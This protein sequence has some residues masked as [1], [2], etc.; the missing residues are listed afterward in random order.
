MTFWEKT[1]FNNTVSV[2]FTAIIIAVAVMLV[3]WI[4]KRFVM[5]RLFR[6]VSKTDTLVDDLCAQVLKKT[7]TP[8]MVILALYVGSL[9]LSL[10]RTLEEG[11]LNTIAVITLLVQCAFWADEIILFWIR[12]YQQKHIKDDAERV[13][14]A[15]AVSFLARL[16]LYSVLV[17][18]A[19]DNI[20]GVEVTTLIASLGIGGIAVALAVQNILADLFASFSITLDKPFVIGDF[21]ILGDFMGTVEHIGLKTTRIR[22]LFGELIVIPNNDLL[23][24]R[25]KNYKHMNERRIAFSVQVT[26]DTP[27]DKIEEIPSLIQSIIEDQE[28]TRFDRAHFKALDESGLTFEVVYYMLD[29]DYNEYMDTQQAINLSLYRRF[30]EEEISFAYPTQTVH[31]QSTNPITPKTAAKTT[32]KKA[33]KK[34][35]TTATKKK[36][37]AGPAKKKTA[38]KST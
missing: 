34:K 21:I 16:V 5:Q 6:L 31:V 29:P 17:L 3:L 19:L 18:L 23:K 9:A 15:R 2:W 11:W 8:F 12:V 1:L 14:T 33:A 38:K 24:S 22:S 27:A 4:L 25:I 13:T 35:T 20:P 7:K 30:E 32:K 36:S 10:P 37:K 26:Y 28:K